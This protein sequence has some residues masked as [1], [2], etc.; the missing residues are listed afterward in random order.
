MGKDE[1]RRTLQ[2]LNERQQEAVAHDDRPLLIVAGA[3]TGKT[4]T[5]A[6]RVAWLIANGTPPGRIL[7]LTFTRRAALEMLQRVDDV[8]RGGACRGTQTVGRAVWGGTFHSV[9][10]R[11]LRRHGRLVG[12]PDSFTV[13]DRSDSADLLD[14]C[15]A[16]VLKDEPLDMEPA[17]AA[18]PRTDRKRFPQKTL[19]ASIYGR[20]VSSERPLG[21]VLERHYP[22][23]A[24]F[25]E[26]IG[27]IFDEYTRRKEAAVCLDYDDLL[28]FWLQMLRHDTCGPVLREQFD[29]VLV[30]EYQD[31]N[32]L[33]ARL[34]EAL[35][36]DGRGLT[37]VG[38]DAQAIY[39]FR[40]ATV[41]NIRRFPDR[42][43]GT[44]IVTLEVNY[45][46]TQ[47]ILD[48]A[49][50]LICEAR[51]AFRKRLRAARTPASAP[52][53]PVLVDC[54]DEDE[55]VA[56]V[57]ERVLQLREEGVPLREQ[58]VLFRAG[59]HSMQLELELARR[60]IP[61]IKYGGL[62]FSETAHVKDV[63]AFLRLAENPRDEVAGRR[64]LQL[65]PGIGTRR[66]ERLLE[67]LHEDGPA[68]TQSTLFA[69]WYEASVP[70]ATRP[71]WLEFVKLF[72]QLARAGSEALSVS[73]QL[74][75][76]CCFYQPLL[77]ERHEDAQA[78]E[79]D[80]RQLER[81][82]ERYAS[83]RQ[84]IHE[85]TLDPP[86]ATQDWPDDPSRDEDYLTL[87]TIHSA[88][89]LEWEA[90]FVLHVADGCIPSDLATESDEQIEEERRLLYVAMTRARRLLHLLFPHRYY[91]RRR[92][93][94][95]SMAL[96]CRFL[97]AAVLERFDRCPAFREEAE[98]A[99]EAARPHL[100]TRSV[101]SA[102]GALW[103]S[104]R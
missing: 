59:W 49:N 28:V 81:L 36:P 19:L 71:M 4:T 86:A 92:Q 16:A 10:T 101:R 72:E 65:L 96:P 89:G 47:P 91:F 35:R 39:S 77:R 8:L 80:L 26:V 24:E 29:H 62:R 31:T 5:L 58:A 85:L 83:R 64:V 17:D 23:L 95:Y 87:S 37:V 21:E 78:R 9:A 55:Q 3:G 41:E 30:D 25:R 14:A 97:T 93:D 38:D 88:K 82:A 43:P 33:Q 52:T 70:H 27:R 7:L 51:D 20:C 56:F 13:L 42:F 74:H 50:A 12:L 76:I 61:F 15:R 66:A 60:N 75:A 44:R 45:R 90:V 18:A 79:E 100:D 46:S 94:E 2:G 34:L 11:L 98:E 73:A 104:N 102:L 48:A 57:V 99:I 1:Q 68:G 103:A 84:F 54:C 22:W 69:R 6:R 53:R 63:V 40:A 67:W 32:P